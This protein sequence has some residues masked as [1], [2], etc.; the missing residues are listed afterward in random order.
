[1]EMIRRLH[2]RA[3]PCRPLFTLQAGPQ[4]LRIYTAR[5]STA[6]QCL[7]RAQR[8]RNLKPMIEDVT[9]ITAC[10]DRER[11]LAAV[12]PSWIASNPTRIIIVDWGSQQPLS[13][14]SLQLA[15]GGEKIEIHRIE[16]RRWVASWAFNEA[17]LR[18]SSTYVCK[19]DCEYIISPTIFQDHHCGTSEFL[20]GH[21]RYAPVGQQF[22]NG[23][24]LASLELL[25]T[26]GGYDERI[27]TY[28]AADGNLYH[29]LA[30]TGSGS[31]LFHSGTITH[32]EQD[33]ATRTE[34]QHIGLEQQLAET[35]NT[36]V[37]TFLIRRNRLFVQYLPLWNQNALMQRLP[38][39]CSLAMRPARER[40]ALAVATLECFD[41]FCRLKKL[42]ADMQGSM[43]I[44]STIL[45]SPPVTKL[46]QGEVEESE[47]VGE[48]ERLRN[49]LIATIQ[50]QKTL[51][52]HF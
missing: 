13:H 46:Y 24:V 14:R 22:I 31:A 27:V 49:D 23:A 17:L 6:P 10:M 3:P 28:G 12:L 39:P 45:A 51:I 11:N 2:C 50:L 19:L 43:A 21:W 30:E 5:R 52:E 42:S 18:C 37:T 47:P 15:E 20:R 34:N 4:V 26:V 1:M 7:I 8:Q 38:R 35:L 9:L 16:Q 40:I 33:A 25:L 41:H 29:R 48:Y 32:I 36:P 44:L